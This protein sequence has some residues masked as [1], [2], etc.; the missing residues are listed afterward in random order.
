[1]CEDCGKIFTS[2]NN[3]NAHKKSAHIV[4]KNL[5]CPQCDKMCPDKHRL[6]NHIN[7]VHEKMPCS[8]C[9]KMFGQQNMK[10]HILQG[11]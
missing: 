5:P 3:F 9:G 6:K 2:L 4:S 7:E 10:L 8:K 11:V 1:M